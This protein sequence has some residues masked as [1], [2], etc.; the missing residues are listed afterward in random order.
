MLV[1]L[2]VRSL[3][4]IVARVHADTRGL[5][6]GGLGL[7]TVARGLCHSSVSSLVTSSPYCCC[8]LSNKII[9]DH[10]QSTDEK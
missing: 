3:T 1:S 4:H 10:D 5:G 2:I 9:S 8:Y 7:V 6:Q